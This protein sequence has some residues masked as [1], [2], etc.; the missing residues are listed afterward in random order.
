MTA[1]IF[2]NAGIFKVIVLK[3]SGFYLARDSQIFLSLSS[4]KR[5]FSRLSSKLEVVQAFE[6][7]LAFVIAKQRQCVFMGAINHAL[8]PQLTLI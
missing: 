7:A 4:L 6:P 1:K 2:P 8:I 5:L 3:E